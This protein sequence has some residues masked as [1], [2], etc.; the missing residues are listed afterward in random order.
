MK[1][2]IKIKEVEL[3]N[4]I[5]LPLKQKKMILEWRNH[6]DIRKWMYNQYEISLDEH[7]NF[8]ESLK[9][10]K[11]KLYF[12]VKKNSKYI[13]VIDFYDIDNNKKEAK[14]GLYKNPYEKTVGI[15]KI[16]IETVIEFAFNILKLKKLKLE[17]FNENKKA[18][19]LYKRYNFR[20]IGEK[21]INNKKI[22]CMELTNE[23]RQ[24]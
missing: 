13:G 18:R 21:V 7:L 2:N 24:S 17:V 15:G 19:N 14:F 23:N 3:I 5:Y 12:L 4:F 6:P 11:D 16:L 20:K 8:I 10:K 22:I 9:N 1:E